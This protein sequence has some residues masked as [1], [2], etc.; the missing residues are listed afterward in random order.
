MRLISCP[1]SEFGKIKTLYEK[2]ITGF[3]DLANL[4]RKYLETSE[5]KTPL[6]IAVFGRPGSGKSTAIKQ[7]INSI[8]PQ[9]KS[10]PLTFNLAQFS[11]VDQLTEAF[12][13]VQDQV[14]SSHEVPLVIFDEFDSYF[15][16]HHLGWL[17]FFLAPMQDG[18]FRG[19]TG[20]YRIGR[21]IFLFSGGTSYNFEQFSGKKFGNNNA[22]NDHSD[23][24]NKDA[25]LNDFISR[26]RGYLDVSGINKE[27]EELS[28]CRLIK[29]RR[30]ILLRALLEE[31]V[32]PI[33][34]TVKDKKIADIHDDVIQAFLN[35]K[36]Y[37]YEV[38]SMV[39]IIQM[40]RWINGGFVPASLPSRSQLENHVDIESFYL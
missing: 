23:T 18:L 37:K 36:T 39:A 1:Y 32:N 15:N 31:H 12:H 13:Q 38:R 29:L 8:N 40:S 16:K 25:K 3:L 5:W 6:S 2:E 33:F 24:I 11:S 35:T 30:A 26:L 28:Q 34:R 19:K 20:D 10:D 9:R 17:K 27:S 21:A 14:L 4:I 22:E 7:I